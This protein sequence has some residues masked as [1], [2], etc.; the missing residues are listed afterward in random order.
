M[1]VIDEIDIFF[2]ERTQ[3]DLVSIIC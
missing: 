3:N 1:T 2:A